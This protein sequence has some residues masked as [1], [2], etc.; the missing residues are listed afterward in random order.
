MKRIL[1]IV[2]HRDSVLVMALVFGLIMGERIRPL[3]DISMWSLAFVMVFSTTG[4]T[5]RSWIPVS[6]MLRPLAISLFLNYVVFGL[7]IIG[8][9]WIFFHE[10]YFPFFAGLVLIAAAPPGPSVIPFSTLIDGDT[11]FSVTGVFGLHLLAMLLTPLILLIILGQALI[12][13]V[14]I[15]WIMARLILIPLVIS[16]LLRH[17]RILPGVE[18]VRNTAVKWGFFL[19]VSPI[20]GMSVPV[21]QSEPLFVLKISGLIFFA[22][23]VMGSLYHYLMVIMRKGRGFI[24]SSTLMMVIK[25]SAFAA[26]AAF[27][28]FPDDPRV[29]LPSAVVSVF[30]TLFIIFY[31]MLVRLSGLKK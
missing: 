15:F 25:S 5:F 2:N 26:V 23:F 4:F 14:E 27:R 1:N 22:M 11:S 31:S 30:V 19:V 16:R 3:A 29:A 28:F 17:P 9:S 7:T 20:V 13:P 12:N 10:S 21:L 18:K 24:I 6:N 8:L